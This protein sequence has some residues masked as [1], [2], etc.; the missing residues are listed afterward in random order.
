MHEYKSLSTWAKLDSTD[1]LLAPNVSQDSEWIPN[2]K[3]G[4]G[5][6]AMNY[7]SINV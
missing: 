1:T 3:K 6:G 7:C 5:E 2:L 4:T